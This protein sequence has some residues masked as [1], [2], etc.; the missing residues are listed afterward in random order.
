MGEM[1]CK[2]E[3]RLSGTDKRKKEEEG[4]Y[5]WWTR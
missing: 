2:E 5:Q 4:E 1:R 3:K